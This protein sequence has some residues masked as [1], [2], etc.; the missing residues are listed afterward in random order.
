VPGSV[1]EYF[2][3]GVTGT[4]FWIDP[5]EQIV[6]VLICRRPSSGCITAT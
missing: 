6:V 3:G 5:Q 2:W 4:Y 1:G